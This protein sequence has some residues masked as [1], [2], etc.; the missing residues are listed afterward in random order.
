MGRSVHE[1]ENYRRLL[2]QEELARQRLKIM[3]MVSM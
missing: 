2:H 3:V 1:D